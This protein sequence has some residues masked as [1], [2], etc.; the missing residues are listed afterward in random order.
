MKNKQ[1]LLK[2]ISLAALIYIESCHNYPSTMPKNEYGLIEI[3]DINK[4]RSIACK[5]SLQLMIDL[6]KMVPGIIIDLRYASINN[7]IHR[8]MYPPGT[9]V[10]FLK[11]PVAKALA[12]VQENLKTKGYCLKIF[13]AYRPY[14][15]T[16]KFWE[17]VHD[18]RYVA[19]PAK[20]SGHNRGI[21]VDITLTN[22]KTKQDLVMG[23][24][25]DNFS[26]TAHHSFTALPQQVLNNRKLLKET[27][28]HYGFNPLETEW[29]HYSWP[30]PQKFEILNVSFADLK[31]ATN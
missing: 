21:A 28:M 22:L 7:F 12:Q 19:H 30:N 13:D 2:I 10:T 17:L 25:F 27:M 29:W 11:L 16:K 9:S 3:K 31:K 14:S 24:G 8:E 6:Q 20:G 1:S 23:T 18:E 26:D 15:V 4:Y 5:D